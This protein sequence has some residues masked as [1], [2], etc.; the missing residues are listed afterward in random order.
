MT[1]MRD[2]SINTRNITNNR[3]LQVVSILALLGLVVAYIH[4]ELYT[5]YGPFVKVRDWGVSPTW[6]VM[7]QMMALS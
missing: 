7:V 6:A 1:S 4:A 2:Y 3:L 5:V